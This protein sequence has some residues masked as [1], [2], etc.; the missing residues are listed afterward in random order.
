MGAKKTGTAHSRQI[1]PF[2]YSFVIAMRSNQLKLST[3]SQ[4]EVNN[5]LVERRLVKHVV[6]ERK[7]RKYKRN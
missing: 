2:I 6:R 4:R 5:W 1:D 7:S 3:F